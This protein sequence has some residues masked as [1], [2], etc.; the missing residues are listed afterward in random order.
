MLKF[1]LLEIPVIVLVILLVFIELIHFF[2]VPLSFKYRD[3]FKVLVSIIILHISISIGTIYC[4]KE[5]LNAKIRQ[6]RLTPK[7]STAQ[8]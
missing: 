7:I 6:L 3:F 5:F 1:L 8:Y 2:G 4:E